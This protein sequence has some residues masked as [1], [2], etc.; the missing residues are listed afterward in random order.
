MVT[1]LSRSAWTKTPNGRAGRDLKRGDVS[2]IAVHYPASGNMRHAGESQTR[3]AQRLEEWRKLHTRA[4]RSWA[5]IGYNYA[6]DQA[7]RV[8]DLTGLNR[9]AH[10]GTAKANRESVGVLLIVGNSERPTAA[11]LAAFRELRSW[12]I[13]KLPKATAVRPHSYYVGTGCPGN[14]VRALIASG[15][16]TAAPSKPTPKPKPDKDVVPWFESRFLNVKGDDDEGARTLKKR[17]PKIVADLTK[18]RPDLIGLCEIRTGQANEHI[19]PRMVDA[20][21]IAVHVAAGNALYALRGTEVGYRGTYWLPDRVQG[22]GRREALLRARV[23]VNG[24]WLHVGVTHLD[25]R[26]GPKFDQLRVD[27][28]D[29]VIA[30]MIRF[31]RRYELTAKH[32]SIIMLDSNSTGWVRDKAFEPHGYVVAVKEWVDEQYVGEGRPVLSSYTTHTESDH[33]IQTAVIGK[34]A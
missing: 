16:L 19:T 5:D 24:H 20:G 12:I 22:E 11:M 18:G 23:K 1:I 30:A 8:W 2:A 9:G 31:G 33:R 14:T 4:P 10:A 15:E 32:R 29:A 3:T 17:A 27:Q 25:Y 26:N 7:G 13:G 28:A 21:Y 34:L 6:V